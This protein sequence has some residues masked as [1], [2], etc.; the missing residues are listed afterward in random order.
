MLLIKDEKSVRDRKSKT[1]GAA[2]V[3]QSVTMHVLS[4]GALNF[5]ERQSIHFSG[6]TNKG[7]CIGPIKLR[8]IED[9]WICTVAEKRAIYGKKI[10]IPVGGKVPAERRTD[11]D[12]RS[13]D[14]R[15]RTASVRGP[16]KAS[17]TSQ[18]LRCQLVWSLTLCGWQCVP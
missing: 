1:R 5:P 14:S 6:Q 17:L 2:S 10:R 4:T 8:P 11:E 12:R 3:K 18:G 9:E 7:T 15:A 16:A 13:A